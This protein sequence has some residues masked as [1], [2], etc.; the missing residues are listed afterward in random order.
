MSS[1]MDPS[2]TGLDQMKAT[3]AKIDSKVMGARGG[4]FAGGAIRTTL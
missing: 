3:P 4:I 1:E 2:I